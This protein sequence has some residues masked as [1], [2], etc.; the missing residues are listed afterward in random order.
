LIALSGAALSK[1]Q[2]RFL[3]RLAWR[4]GGER[5]TTLV[6]TVS[7]I[8]GSFK[9]KAIMGLVPKR[10]R[11][12]CAYCGHEKK[13]TRD[14][15]P[16]K[17]WLEVP[18][19]QNLITV[20]ACEDCNR[21]FKHDDEYVRTVVA[22]D[23][24]AQSN[25]TA[26][27]KLPEVFR[28]LMKPEAEA[29]RERIIAKVNASRLVDPMGNPLGFPMEVDVKRIDAVGERLVRGLHFHE[30]KQP[31]PQNAR[32]YVFSKPGITSMDFILPQFRTILAKCAA[33]RAKTIGDGFSYVAGA[34]AGAYVWLILLYGYFWWFVAVVPA[35]ADMT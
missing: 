35:D 4:G 23:L 10:R 28:S 12:V 5:V 33:Q 34:S 19:P 18:Y 29:F 27:S 3:H 15:V 9:L 16:P 22:L 26:V 11:G 25:Y 31:L 1:G 20:P 24:R 32:S 13:L 2:A 7:R 17:L 21:Q 8:S 30:G 14:H 6:L